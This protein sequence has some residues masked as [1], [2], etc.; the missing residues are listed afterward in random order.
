VRRYAG[1]H[2]TEYNG[3]A[4]RGNEKKGTRTHVS[5]GSGTETYCD[6]ERQV[7]NVR[8]NQSQKK[9]KLEEEWCKDHCNDA[10]QLQKNVDGRAGGVLEWITDGVT[11]DSCLVGI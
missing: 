5:P 1:V 6:S 3:H 11:T 2:V 10:H 4:H 9:V 8:P 7:P